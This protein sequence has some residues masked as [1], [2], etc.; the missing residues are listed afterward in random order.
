MRL[1]Q[2]QNNKVHWVFEADQVPQFAPHI[3]LLDVTNSPQVQEGWGYVNGAFV[4][5]VPTF[6]ELKAAK[7]AEIAAVRWGHETGGLQLNGLVVA[8]DRES[9]SLINA[10][11]TST[12]LDSAYTVRWKMA[13]GFFDLDAPAIQT[14]AAAVRNHVQACFDREA[15]L[16]VAVDAAIDAEAV[17]LISWKEC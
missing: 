4:D 7:K 14:I 15:E 2:I 16:C 8:T 17:N 1:A 9:Q 11:V 13:N 6:D 10:A 5:P 3:V 12:I